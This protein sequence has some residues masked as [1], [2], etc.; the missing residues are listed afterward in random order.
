[1][2]NRKKYVLVSFLSLLLLLSLPGL[3]WSA[4]LR[5]TVDRA[6]VKARI[7]VARWRGHEPRLVSIS[8]KLRLPGAQVQA[9]DSRSG[10]ATLADNEGRFTLPDLTWYPGAAYDLVIS[11]GGDEGEL[12]KVVAPD[13]FPEGAVFKVDE[14][15]LSG[16]RNVSLKDLPGVNSVTYQ[17]YDARN[18]HYYK[19]LFDALT[20][21]K[22]SEEARL[23]AINNYVA[24]KKIEG[25]SQSSFKSP[26]QTLE[27]GSSYCGHLCAAMRSIL[28]AGGY[29]TR[30]IHLCESEDA[31]R[32][33]A[34]V[35]IYCGGEWH[36]YDPTF[37]V[38]FKNRNQ[39]VA[40]YKEMRLDASLISEEAFENLK[41]N[42]RRQLF[43]SLS[44]MY[45]SGH[46]HF[47]YFK[48]D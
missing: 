48:N 5:H 8:G 17:D 39:K 47:Y 32:S 34:V 15:D 3:P 18:D 23:E 29:S 6:I 21:G 30:E 38:R 36:L 46:H 16:A 9:L 24:S 11:D 7:T 13:D 43:A 44:S 20:A 2:R 31:S 45:R 41:P 35:E 42:A 14:I 12:V 37:G 4:R 33:H 25:P 22:E 40:S 1:M 19:E 28:K 26:R 10:W 27:G